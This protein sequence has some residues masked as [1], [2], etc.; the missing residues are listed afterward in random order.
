MPQAPYF[1]KEDI[2]QATAIRVGNRHH[3]EYMQP[4]TSSGYNLCGVYRR[5][6]TSTFTSKFFQDL[7]QTTYMDPKIHF[8]ESIEAQ[9]NGEEYYVSLC[10]DR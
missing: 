1:S 4:H 5:E 9:A 3:A 7:W 6:D 2:T 8:Y 10:M